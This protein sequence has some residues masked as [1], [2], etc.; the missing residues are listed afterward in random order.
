[1]FCNEQD[2][3]ADVPWLKQYAIKYKVFIHLGFDDQSCPLLMHA[4]S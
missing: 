4:F 1:M 2:M 3:E